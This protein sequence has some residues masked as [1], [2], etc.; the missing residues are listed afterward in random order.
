MVEKRTPFGVDGLDGFQ[1]NSTL[2]S[3]FIIYIFPLIRG[4]GYVGVTPL[5]LY[6]CRVIKVDCGRNEAKTRVMVP[7][8]VKCA[9]IQ[10]PIMYH[11]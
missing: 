9:S 4:L 5:T 3:F 8:E 6:S 1:S 7:R 11:P 2:E 10:I